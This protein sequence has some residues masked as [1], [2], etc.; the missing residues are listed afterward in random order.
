VLSAQ[1]YN[2]D[3]KHSETRKEV[4]KTSLTDIK[5]KIHHI[6]FTSRG[7]S[8][9]SIQLV[10]KLG[11][12]KKKTISAT[13]RMVHDSTTSKFKTSSI[14]GSKFGQSVLTDTHAHIKMTR[15]ELK[16]YILTGSQDGEK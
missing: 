16:N 7:Y 9:Y 11:T 6:V 12:H 3:V 15:I 5:K 1:E 10:S 13:Q 14:T 8:P 2:L 4:S